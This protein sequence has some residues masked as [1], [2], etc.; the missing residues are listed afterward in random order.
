MIHNF[1]CPTQK[2]NV[3][4]DID[5]VDASDMEEVILVPTFY[6]CTGETEECTKDKCPIFTGKLK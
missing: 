5:Y 2:I 3:S 4:A 6:R 1:K